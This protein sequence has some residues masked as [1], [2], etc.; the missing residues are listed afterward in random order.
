MDEFAQTTVI[1]LLEGPVFPSQVATALY[2]V[3]AKPTLLGQIEWQS[4]WDSTLRH[5]PNAL[6]NFPDGTEFGALHIVGS[7]NSFISATEL[8]DKQTA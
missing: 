5:F 8:L 4:A 6:L 7:K 2:N 3:L 1:R